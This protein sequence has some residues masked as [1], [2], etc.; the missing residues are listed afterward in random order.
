MQRAF[1][2]VV[3]LKDASQEV[4]LLGGGRVRG[5]AYLPFLPHLITHPLQETPEISKWKDL[6]DIGS[7]VTSL[8]F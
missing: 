5:E 7:S 8:K 2:G 6:Q 4:V 3:L 1:R